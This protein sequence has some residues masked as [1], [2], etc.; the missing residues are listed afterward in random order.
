MAA[1]LNWPL[2]LEERQRVAD[3]AGG[4]SETW[5]LRGNLWGDVVVRGVSEADAAAGE[6]SRVRYRITLRGAQ[7]GDPARPRVGDR[8]VSGSRIFDVEAVTEKDATGRY[9]VAWARE[10]VLQ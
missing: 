2:R 4:F 5:V 9:L 1:H 8:L 7:E 3:G 6:F 10:E